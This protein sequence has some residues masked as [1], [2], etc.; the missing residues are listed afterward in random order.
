MYIIIYL[1]GVLVSFCLMFKLFSERN[2]YKLDR[3]ANLIGY[4]FCV[5]SW[6]CV[7]ILLYNTSGRL[8]R[9]W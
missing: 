2:D 1:I 5:T 8:F 7:I 4:L 9:R 3:S 6:L